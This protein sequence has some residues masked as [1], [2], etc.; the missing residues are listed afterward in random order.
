M[1]GDYGTS[2]EPPENKK[3]CKNPVINPSPPRGLGM[4]DKNEKS[5]ISG[6]ERPNQNRSDQRVGDCWEKTREGGLTGIR[7]DGSESAR[8]RSATSHRRCGARD[9]NADE[10]TRGFWRKKKKRLRWPERVEVKERGGG[11]YFAWA[12][13]DG[14][15]VGGL[16]WAHKHG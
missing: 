7:G 4:R 5:G 14:P 2:E 11:C 13:T 3:N 9:D 12:Y 6:E 16:V 8:A 10:I 1:R 15:N